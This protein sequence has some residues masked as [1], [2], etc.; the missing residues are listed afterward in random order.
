MMAEA[1]ANDLGAAL[2]PRFFVSEDLAS[3]RLV[4]LFDTVLRLPSAYHLVYPENR[5]LRPVAARF[6]DWLLAEAAAGNG[7]RAW[8]PG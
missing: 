5:G 1:A 6:R 8:L 7:D 3:G 2:V 4:Q